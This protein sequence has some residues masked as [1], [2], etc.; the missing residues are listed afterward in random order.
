MAVVWGME[1]ADLLPPWKFFV[2][3]R[4]G[5]ELIVA[6]T[7]GIPVGYALLSYACRQELPYLYMDMVAVHPDSQGQK[8]GQQMIALAKATAAA[9]S[10][11]SLEWTYDP[12]ECANANLYIRKLGG[13]G[14]RYYRDYYGELSGRSHAGGPTDRLWVAL[15]TLGGGQRDG[16]PVHSTSW[17]NVVFSASRPPPVPRLDLPLPP[18][19]GISVPRVFGRIRETDQAHADHVREM[20]GLLFD[21]LVNQLE[22]RAV[23]FLL[24]E[25][26]NTYVLRA[27]AA[28]RIVA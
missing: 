26:E 4:T 3:P 10:I 6:S 18:V 9:R 21:R 25:Q 20:S 27:H 17:P 13:V 15:A 28:D 1:D 8:L 2:T 19:V 16:T 24:G 23:D 22:Y 12:L 7:N 14:L 11:G 5:G